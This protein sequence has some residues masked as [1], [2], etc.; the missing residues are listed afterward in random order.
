MRLEVVF[1]VGYLKTQSAALPS[2]PSCSPTYRAAEGSCNSSKSTCWEMWELGF[3]DMVPEWLWTAKKNCPEHLE[4]AGS[5]YLLVLPAC[6]RSGSQKPSLCRIPEVQ[7]A[8]GIAPP[9]QEM[10]F[11]SIQGPE[12]YRTPNTSSSDVLLLLD[13]A[14]SI[15]GLISTFTQVDKLE[16]LN[17]VPWQVKSVTCRQT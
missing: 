12:C 13:H 9:G 10:L 17:M 16:I 15:Q 6:P 2:P 3:P 11:V 5:A 14:K 1:R 4:M 8:Y 7:G